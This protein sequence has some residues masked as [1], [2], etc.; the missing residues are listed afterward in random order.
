MINNKRICKTGVL[1]A[2]MTIVFAIF[3]FKAS[4]WTNSISSDFLVYGATTGGS[5]TP[6]PGGGTGGTTT[7]KVVSQVVA[8]AYDNASHYGT[9]IEVVN[10]NNSPITVSGNFYKDDGSPSTLTFATNQS[11]QPTFSGSFSNL[12][13]PASAILVL[14]LGTDPNN[15]PSE[16]SC[17]KPASTPAATWVN[18]CTNWGSI[19]AN[20]TISVTTFFELRRKGDEFLYSR[21]G[22]PSSRPDMTSFVIPRV[23]ERGVGLGEIETGFAVENTGSR[24]A[25]ITAKVIDVNGTTIATGSFLLAPNAHKVGFVYDSSIFSFQNPET[26]GR[27]YHY[28]LFSTDQPTIGATALSIDS[29]Y[30]ALTSFPVDPIS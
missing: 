8:G 22:I 16:G 30:G 11:S 15:T 5:T 1:A 29:G 13:L 6:P 3:A 19:T 21:V 4:E 24:T 10:P 25:T 18:P 23:R 26:T 2:A 27:Q 9:I 12:N 14:R 17:V 7:T 20:N 28:V